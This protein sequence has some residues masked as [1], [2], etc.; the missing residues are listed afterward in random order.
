MRRC[1]FVVG[2]LAVMLAGCA[3]TGPARH[4]D[5]LDAAANPLRSRF[6]AARAKVRV[7]M[8]VSPT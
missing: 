1:D 3:P 6:N 5:T 8:L 4:F 7:L 2:S